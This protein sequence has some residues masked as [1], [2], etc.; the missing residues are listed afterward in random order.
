MRNTAAESDFLSAYPRFTM[1]CVGVCLIGTSGYFLV[2]SPG[3]INAALPILA[4]L[5]LGAQRILP[6]LQQMYGS[7]ANIKAYK[8]P[9]D[10]ILMALEMH[11]DNTS[12]K[13]DLAEK[14]LLEYIEFKNVSFKFSDNED[15]CVLKNMSFRIEKGQRI[16]IIGETGSGKSTLVDILM[17]LLTPSNGEVFVDGVD[18]F[19]NQSNLL[20]AW[21]R[22]IAHVPQAIFLSDCSIAENIAFSQEPDS[23][24]MGEVTMAASMAQ[25]DSFIETLPSGY[26]TNVGERGIK[27]SG[28]QRQRIG[29]AR[30][31]FSKSSMLIL[32]EATSALDTKTEE[33]LM[34]AISM[35]SK[36]ITIVIIAHRLSTVMC[37]D[38]I[39]RISNGALVDDGSP[40]HVIENNDLNSSGR[41]D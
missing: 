21:R 10:N 14:R 34:H 16:G 37:C 25:I 15:S 30:A 27:L 19:N 35:L 12:I 36:D 24:D 39:L 41:C 33:N 31:L 3:D 8:R 6:A 9:C 40:I 13:S 17:G 1:E 4:V 18:I 20:P 26:Q 28:G 7:W 5:A 22:T 29:I 23:I 2:Q 38:R 11:I 32:D